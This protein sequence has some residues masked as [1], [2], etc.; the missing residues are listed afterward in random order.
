MASNPVF[1]VD[2]SCICIL[3]STWDPHS[4]KSRTVRSGDHAGHEISDIWKCASSLINMPG[5]T[6]I[7]CHWTGFKVAQHRLI[8]GAQAWPPCTPM[9]SNTVFCKVSVSSAPPCTIMCFIMWTKL[10]ILSLM[11]KKIVWH[12]YQTCVGY[13]NCWLFRILS[14]K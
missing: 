6:M 14:R 3:S 2:N 8:F 10:F 7:H 5:T 13:K 9:Y 11:K 1:Y 4:K 12:F